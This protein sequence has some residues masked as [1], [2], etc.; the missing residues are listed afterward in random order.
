ME[1][2]IS[3]FTEQSEVC[4]RSL[5][6]R[7]KVSQSRT[8]S[9]KWKRDSWTQHLSGRILKPSLGMSFAGRWTYSLEGSLV[10]HSRQQEG[11][12]ET[13]TLGISSPTFWTALESADLPLFSLRTLKESCPQNSQEMDGEIL[14]ELPFSSM[15][16]E[17]W[18]GWVTEQRQEFSQ[19]LKSARLT[20]G[21][22]SLSWPSPIASEARQGFQD[23]SRGMR[24]SQESLTTVVIMHGPPV[25]ASSSSHGSR[26]G[27]LTPQLQDSKHSGTNPTANGERDLLVNQVNWATPRSGKTTDENPETWALRQAKGDVATMPLTAQVKCWPTI[28]AG[29]YRTPPT[30]SGIA[31]QTIMPSSEHALP[32]A[33][34]GKLNPRWVETLMGLP[35][36]WTMPSCSSPVTIAPMNFDSSE[37][38]LCQQQQSVHS[39]PYLKD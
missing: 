28:C 2:L 27:W 15:S 7:S 36:G 18:K 9:Q 14:P 20:N 22:G 12:K 25:P 26:P 34:G 23:R 19:R 37:T 17:S 6:L 29:D 4:A 13:K 32:K 10:N 16:S 1:E 33:A 30:N 38:E 11:A 31:G 24:G 8:W 3:D 5:I 39:E 35:I 21:S